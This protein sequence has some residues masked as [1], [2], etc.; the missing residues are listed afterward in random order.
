[1]PL[2]LSGPLHP[3]F[4]LQSAVPRPPEVL[5]FFNRTPSSLG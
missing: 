2:R 1:M 5:P 3:K 4:S